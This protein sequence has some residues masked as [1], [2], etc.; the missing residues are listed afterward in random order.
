MSERPLSQGYE[1]SRRR[2]VELVRSAD[3]GRPVPA[4]PAWDVHDVVAHLSGS[5]ETLVA[6]DRPGRDPQPWI[7]RI[8]AERRGTPVPELLERWAACAEAFSAVVD[9]RSWGALAD[10]V[11]HEHDLRAA[12]GRPGARQEPEVAEV[13]RLFLRVHAPHLEEAGLGPLAVR[14]PV[15]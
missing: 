1:A 13:V 5:A 2:I 11:V 9:G 7:D 3:A 8:I 12:L 10:I 6:G 15:G 4:C 14:T